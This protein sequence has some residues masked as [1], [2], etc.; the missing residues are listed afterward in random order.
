MERDDKILN[1]PTLFVIKRYIQNNV[2]VLM[3]M[4]DVLPIK[5]PRIVIKNIDKKVAG[6]IPPAYYQDRIIYIDTDQLSDPDYLVHE[7]AHYLADLIPKQTEEILLNEYQKFLD[8]YFRKSKRKKDFDLGGDEKRKMREAIAKKLG[9]P[10]SYAF[11]NFDELFA[12]II[13][14]WKRLPN[15]AASY[16]FKKSMKRVLTRL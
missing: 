2:R 5:K 16:K 4:R 15:N 8:E 9:L 7:Y 13:M 14:H 12:E 11:T 3:G 6:V 10:S 1:T